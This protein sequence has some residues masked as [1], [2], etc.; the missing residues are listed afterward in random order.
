MSILEKLR[1]IVL[2]RKTYKNW[3]TIVLSISKYR[4]YEDTVEVIIPVL[5]RNGKEASIPLPL[6][7]G[8]A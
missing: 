3:I 5:P 8:Y 6:I 1:T 2:L 4:R 7:F